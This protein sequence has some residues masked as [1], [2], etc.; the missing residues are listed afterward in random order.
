LHA[1]VAVRDMN[2][3]SLRLHPLKGRAKGRWAVQVSGNWRVT[4]AFV[5]KDA[6]GVDY[7]DYH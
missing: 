2:L 5:G 3:T 6:S 4:F 1:A 7:E